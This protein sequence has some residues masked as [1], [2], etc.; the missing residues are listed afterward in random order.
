MPRERLPQCIPAAS[1]WKPVI[2]EVGCVLIGSIGL[3]LLWE[4]LGKRQFVEEIFESARVSKEIQDARISGVSTDFM[5]GVPWGEYL[6]ASKEL[7]AMFFGGK[8]WRNAFYN[9]LLAMARRQGCRINIILPDP[10]IESV[11]RELGAR[12]GYDD[13]RVRHEI[14]ECEVF[15]T[16]LITEAG[17]PKGT[18]RIYHF[19][20]SPLFTF[21]RMDST[22][23]LV[24]YRHN[25]KGKIPT[26]VC[27]KG[28]SLADFI[29]EQMQAIISKGSARVVYPLKDSSARQMGTGQVDT[30][31]VVSP[32]PSTDKR[33]SE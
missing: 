28:G 3:A 4:L 9:K 22:Y 21:Y 27:R 31:Q 13:A 7:D 20:E 1:I 17:A 32:D 12:F 29:D 18:L 10:S 5:D 30:L 33:L 14:A 11:V 8:T 16:N 15:F 2:S 19:A 6:D 26:I 23:V 24:T 25:R